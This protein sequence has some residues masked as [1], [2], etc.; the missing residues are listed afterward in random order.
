MI[1]E[2]SYEKSS[3]ERTVQDVWDDFTDYE[4]GLAYEFI[5]Q[6][7]ELGSYARDCMVVYNDE[8]RK[9]VLALIKEAMHA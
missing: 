4:K 2:L 6:A 7:L 3:K 1:L 8:K 5:G 9:V